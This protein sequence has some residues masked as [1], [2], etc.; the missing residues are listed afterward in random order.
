MR[1]HWGFGVVMLGLCAGVAFADEF[2]PPPMKDGLWETHSV[3][4]Q[5]GKNTSEITIKMCQ[6]KELTQS[7]Q[8]MSQELRK[9]NECIST[10]VQRSGNTTVVESRC[11]KG[12]NA[13]QVVRISYSITGDTALRMEMHQ[14]KGGAEQTTVVDSKYLSSCPA[15]MKGGEMIMPDGKVVGGG[16]TP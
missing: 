4:T 1:T 2:N 12:N 5:A 8:A 3:S 6:T 11:A 15:G 14:Q 13:G 16:G 10:V 9:R 7:S